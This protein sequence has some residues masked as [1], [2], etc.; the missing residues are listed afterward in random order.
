MPE[1]SHWTKLCSEEI[2]KLPPAERKPYVEKVR[3]NHR[4]YEDIIRQM[5]DCLERATLGASQPPCLLVV[6]PTGTG[7]STIM[8]A[9]AADHPRTI[10]DTQTLV[11]VLK[12]TFQHPVK[13]SNMMTDILSA[14]GDPRADKGT[15]GNRRH[16]VD[17]YTK[18]CQTWM[19][20]LDELQHMLDRDNSKL[21]L[22][23]TDWLKTHI[24]G[25][26]T[27]R[28]PIACVCVGLQGQAEQVIAG[29]EQLAR[30]FPDPIILRPFIWDEQNPET[31]KEFKIFLNDLDRLLP[32]NGQSFLAG[33]DLALRI[34]IASGGVISQV[35]ELVRTATRLA[36]GQGAERLSMGLLE[37][38][39]TK[40]LAGKRR[41]IKN[42]FAGKTPQP[43][44]PTRAE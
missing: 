15:V 12:S 9:F 35:M 44:I 17:G 34:Y 20:I 40:R 33:E 29:N 21:L 19:L 43:P 24:K 38:A 36:L 41:K 3:V 4:Q 28:S 22:T 6:G 42:P 5:E 7:K 32:L 8:N 2:L 31:I 26:T 11:P 13:I 18:D 27:E 10:T 14:Y 30:L 1:K 23:A 16:R 25:E 39:F 37:T